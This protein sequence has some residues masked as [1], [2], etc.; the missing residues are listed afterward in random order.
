[1]IR[2]AFEQ[3]ARDAGQRE[4]VAL[5]IDAGD[6]WTLW[7]CDNVHPEPTQCYQVSPATWLAASRAGRIAAVLHSH[8][9][10]SPPS[11]AD[12]DAAAA[13]R[14][15]HH[16]Y[17]VG[18]AAWYCIPAGRRYTGRPFAWGTADCWS[19]VRD[20][21]ASELAIWLPGTECCSRPD[22]ELDEPDAFL[23]RLRRYG[24]SEIAHS[25]ARHGDVLLFRLQ[26]GQCNHSGVL[27]TDNRLLHHIENRYSIVDEFDGVWRRTLTH[28][29][30][31]RNS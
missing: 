13:F 26:A 11:Q 8:P 16:V 1:M 30:R 21:Y 5:V 19:L 12:I 22:W 25:E 23:T 17:A 20:W 28:A 7:P 10:S 31:H 27:L 14:L 9:D 6:S 18:A 15:P 2:A 3:L 4:A 24:F 29:L